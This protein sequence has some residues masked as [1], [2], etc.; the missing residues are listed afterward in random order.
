MAENNGSKTTASSYT[1]KKGIER[2]SVQ[3][4]A[5]KLSLEGGLTKDLTAEIVE[6]IKK[7][8]S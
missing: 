5:S 2:V 3:F 4:D 1:N 7:A 6:A 8:R